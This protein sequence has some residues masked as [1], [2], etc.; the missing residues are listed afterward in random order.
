MRKIL[1][2]CLLSLA[3]ILAANI[4]QALAADHNLAD[5]EKLFQLINDRLA[6][7]KDVAAFK[8]VNKAAI[9]DRAREE[10]VIQKTAEAAGKEGL[11]VES[12]KEF[13]RVQIEA[14]KKIQW[15]WHAEWKKD[16]FPKD[17]KFADLKKEIRPALIDL[18]NKIVTQIKTALPVLHDPAN[19]AELENMIEHAITITYVDR[20]VKL[21]LLKA[22]TTIKAAD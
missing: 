5:A 4:G 22:L 16:G 7:M 8:W 15:G 3:L 19:Q 2:V 20:D 18:G 11:E 17:M 12:T 10:V 13:F 6:Y 1:N 14:A 9:E 21:Q